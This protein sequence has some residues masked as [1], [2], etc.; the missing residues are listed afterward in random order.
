MYDEAVSFFEH[1]IRKDRPVREML[2]A[3]YTFLNQALAKHYGVKKEI[4]SKDQMR[5]GGRRQCVSVAADCF[6]WVRC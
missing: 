5:T 3:D 1:V 2:Y 6:V 4:A